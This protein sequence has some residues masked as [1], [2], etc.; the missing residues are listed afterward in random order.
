MRRPSVDDHTP[1]NVLNTT[2]EG[3]SLRLDCGNAQLRLTFLTDRIV[4]VRAAPG[5]VFGLRRPWAVNTPDEAFAPPATTLN[6]DGPILRFGTDALRVVVQRHPARLS[7][8]TASGQRFAADRDGMQW[9][10]NGQVAFSKTLAPDEQLYGF[11]QRHGP[12]NRRGWTHVNWT[13]DPA[14]IHSISVDPMHIAIPVYVSIQPGLAYGVYVNNTFRSM[15]DAG[16]NHPDELRFEADGGELDYTLVLGPSPEAVGAGLAQILGTTPMPPRWAL[17]YHQSRWSYKTE[18]EVRRIVSQFR[19]RSLP[20]DVIHFDIDYMRGYRVFTWDAARFPD[21]A[22]LIGDLRE[23]HVRAVAIVD[24]GVKV[25]PDYDVYADGL[26]AGHFISQANGEVFEG[27]VWPDLSV[28]P[29][30]ARPAV[31]AWWA[32]L[33]DRLVTVGV[34][35]I[36]NDMNEPVSFQAPFSAPYEGVRSFPDDLPQGEPAEGATHAE[37]HN[38][39]GYLMAQASYNG[40]RKDRPDE[41]PFVL[42]RSAF[43]GVQ[44]HSA[45]WMGDNSSKWEHLRAALPQLMNMGLSGV[46]FVGVDIGGFHDNATPE[47]FA[48]WMQFGVLMPFARGHTAAGTIQQEPWEFGPEVESICRD[49]LR[50]RYRLLPYFY[51]LFWQAHQH[52]TPL[53]RPLAWHWPND[54]KTWHR[55]DE[56]MLGPFLLAAPVMHPGQDHRHVYLPAGVWFDYWTNAQYRGPV[57]VLVAAPLDRLPLFVLGGGILPGRAGD[58]VHTGELLEAPLTIDVYPGTSEFTLYEDDGASNDYEQGKHCNRV[59]R[60]VLSDDWRTLRIEISERMGEFHPPSCEM[61]VRVH[62]VAPGAGMQAE[63]VKTGCEYDG[64]R[65]VLSFCSVDDGTAQQF[66]VQLM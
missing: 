60:T 57:D 10:D 43:A 33:Q 22:G 40:L 7:F 54:R 48:R 58:F 45:C 25:D 11:G 32:G 2:H 24:P 64:A 14:A 35:G 30:F 20:L 36:W 59:V 61:T 12:L 44:R 5:G 18:E 55:D 52:G 4:R 39:Y 66:T 17:G 9:R 13:T 3:A 34:S 50:L 19:E 63:L 53:L 23:Q 27:Y 56:V 28:W 47:L 31:Q 41:R 37:L 49:Y 62:G 26:A 29:D 65:Q 8:E 21:P 16:D 6:G 42:T 1:G 38:M 46:P 51:A 15:F